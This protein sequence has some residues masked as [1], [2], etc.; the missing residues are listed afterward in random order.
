[1]SAFIVP[2]TDLHSA[3]RAAEERPGLRIALVG[4]SRVLARMAFA[5]VA[6][7]VVNPCPVC[8]SRVGETVGLVCEACGT[9]YGA[10]E[11][12]RRGVPGACVFWANGD[13]SVRWANGSILRPM[14]LTARHSWRGYVYDV[15]V[16]REGM[17]VEHLPSEA[18]PAFMTST[19]DRSCDECTPAGPCAAHPWPGLPARAQH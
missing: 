6:T 19:W 17:T 18:I 3:L 1:M 12:P 13:E 5:D 15:A 9:D 16:L 2:T 4:W 7:A 8:S 10:G 11:R 14:A